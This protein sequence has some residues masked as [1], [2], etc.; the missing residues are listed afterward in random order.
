MTPDEDEKTDPL[1]E[2]HRPTMDFERKASLSGGT[3]GWA[4]VGFEFGILVVLFFF[5]GKWLD[6]KFGW[7]PWGATVGA[8]VG[9][10]LGMFL[11]IRRAVRASSDDG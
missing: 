9:V 6:G 2:Y 10:F 3:S 1:G 5:V 8:L 4:A 7:D 11:L